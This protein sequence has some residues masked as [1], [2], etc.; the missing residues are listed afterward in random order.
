MRSH[1]LWGAELLESRPG[2]ELAAIIARWHHE[3]ADGHGYPDGLA[4]DEIPES[5]AVA[6]VADAFDA[7]ISDRPYRSGR[8]AAEAVR[9]IRLN[10]GSQ[11]N[12]RVVA[13][14]EG[15][16]ARGELP[17]DSASR[18]AAAAA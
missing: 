18:H 3:R 7:L 2:F 4:G 10:A 14:L 11:F 8:S 15:L 9:E 12:P 1:T 17:D 16:L 6:Q 13:A 5:V